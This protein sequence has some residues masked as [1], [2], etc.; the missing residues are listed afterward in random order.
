MC[1]LNIESVFRMA[2][3]KSFDNLFSFPM[4][5]SCEQVG[6]VRGKDGWGFQGDL[7][8]VQRLGG[9]EFLF[10]AVWGC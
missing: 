2:S 8:G 3:F 9:L 4:T 6:G 5:K 1:R 7:Y 10:Q